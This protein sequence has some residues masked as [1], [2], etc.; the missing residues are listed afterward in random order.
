MRRSSV[1]VLLA[2][3]GQLSCGGSQPTAPTSNTQPSQLSISGAVTLGEIH[4]SVQL[5]LLSGVQDVTNSATWQ[6]S[7]PAVATVSFGLVRAVALGTA[8]IQATYNAQTVSTSMTVAADQDCIPYDGSNV[9]YEQNTRDVP[10]SWTLISPLPG[11]GLL[12]ALVGADSVSDANNLQALFRRYNQMCFLGRNNGRPNRFQYI[13]TYFKDARG[14]QT[15][16]TPEDCV[17][18]SPAGLQVVQQGASGWALTGGATQLA[19]LDTAL[20]ASLLSAVAVQAS[21]EC[22]IGRGNPR[23]DPYQYITEYWK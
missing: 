20:E 11:G 10:P 18:Y 13:F 22:Y 23:P 2:A 9:S 5:T 17:S 15:V 7:N 16:I 14:Q 1:F 3:L 12:E 19:L 8:T 21:N 6:S 4:P